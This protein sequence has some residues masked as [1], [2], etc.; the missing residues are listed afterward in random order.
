MVNA[1]WFLAPLVLTGGVGLLLLAYEDPTLRRERIRTGAALVVAAL[2]LTGLGLVLD[3]G[4]PDPVNAPSPASG[5]DP[6]GATPGR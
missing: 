2:V 1:L 5:Q 4:S 3:S 6:V